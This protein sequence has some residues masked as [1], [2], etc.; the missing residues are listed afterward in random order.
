MAAHYSQ[1]LKKL[2]QPEDKLASVIDTYDTLGKILEKLQE[3]REGK[4]L[5]AEDLN[6]LAI[7]SLFSLGYYSFWQ[8]YGGVLRPLMLQAI[9][10]E[11][12]IVEEFFVEA[13]PMALT[14]LMPNRQEDYLQMR[15]MTRKAF[16]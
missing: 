2:L 15:E 11:G 1:V 9:A 16:N 14:T 8:A 6:Y 7:N 13:V 12:N 4:Y 3:A 5:S 10:K